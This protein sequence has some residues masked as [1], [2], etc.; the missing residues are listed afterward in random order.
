[1]P[2]LPLKKIEKYLREIFSISN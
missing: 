2:E 1:M